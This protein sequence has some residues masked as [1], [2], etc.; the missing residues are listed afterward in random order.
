MQ[1]SKARGPGGWGATQS[2]LFSRLC[3]G[4]RRFSGAASSLSC[5]WSVGRWVR[6]LSRSRFCP[7]SW[8]SH[9][10]LSG[11]C[12][13]LRRPPASRTREW[14]GCQE[15][16]RNSHENN[17]KP[18]FPSGTER[19]QKPVV[20]WSTEVAQI[21]FSL[22]SLHTCRETLL[23]LHY[24]ASNPPERASLVRLT[25]VSFNILWCSKCC[26]HP[27]SNH[28]WEN[29]EYYNSLSRF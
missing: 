27:L 22:L 19:R 17:G 1:R 25:P 13:E 3:S 9:S 24:G 16:D 5:C 20:E 7:G 11:R 6:S 29:T 2:F 18:L 12:W 15:G 26:F 28:L 23:S 14:S 10:G 4:A 21:P 8:A